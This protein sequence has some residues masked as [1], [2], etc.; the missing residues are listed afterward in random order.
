MYLESVRNPKVQLWSSLKTKKGRREH[1]LFL[2]EGKRLVAE[3]LQAPL[4]L[5]AL[6]WDV[7][8]DELPA[9]WLSLAEARG[10][11]VFHL[12][13]Q[14]FAAVAD[15]VT[16][17]GVMAVAEIPQL[18]STPQAGALFLLL[19]GLQDPG[20]VG[21][22]LRT[23]Q[24]F[25]AA[26]VCCGTG[27]VDPFAPKVVR[28]SM[29]GLFRV[30]VCAAES[31]AYI[32]Q[33]RARFPDGQVVV[34]SPQ[35]ETPCHAINL[36]GPS[37]ILIGSEADGVSKDAAAFATVSVRIPMPGRA[38]SLN[39]AVAGAVLL[40]EAARQREGAGPGGEDH[41]AQW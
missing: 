36:L 37:L 22:L 25:G 10:I 18:A 27:T 38:E 14:A 16:P 29:G 41:G 28:A 20:N 23:A 21:T 2:I 12:S 6:L 30:S 15:T 4:R 32:R 40:Y 24:A 34:A 13:P 9:D 33:W 1:G 17:Q 8:T 31:S 26:E 11:P 19:D 35:A 3:A 39:A 7:G 5:Q